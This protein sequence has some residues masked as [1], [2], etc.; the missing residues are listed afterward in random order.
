MKTPY[1][2]C[3][4]YIIFMRNSYNMADSTTVI[5]DTIYVHSADALLISEQAHNYY[6]ESF[7]TLLWLLT[8]CAA[9]VGFIIPYI[10]KV[11]QKQTFNNELAKVRDE[12][13][14]QIR[15]E[16]NTSIDE[17]EE[18]IKINSEIAQAGVFLLQ[19]TRNFRDGDYKTAFVDYLRSVHGYHYGEDYANASTA[20]NGLDRA[21]DNLTIHEINTIC[22]SNKIDFEKMLTSF[23]EDNSA[24]FPT[25][26]D[27]LAKY[28][29]KINN[30]QSH[31]N[32]D[33]ED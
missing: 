30:N 25:I 29:D 1:L 5:H 2:S 20:L 15:D 23:G 28:N 10:L 16:L 13:H 4:A 33:P 24:L 27:I 6:S 19:A 21:I 18:S 8:A 3:I 7:T 17:L 26:I 31:N 32:E 22:R 14:T 11:G 9:F 12:L